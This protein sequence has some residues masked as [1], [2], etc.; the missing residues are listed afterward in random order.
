MSGIVAR[1][2]AQECVLMGRCPAAGYGASNGYDDAAGMS[3]GYG[4]G[5]AGKADKEAHA[6]GPHAGQPPAQQHGPVR[7]GSMTRAVWMARPGPRR[8]VH[9]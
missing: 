3:A 7:P 6:H 5:G 4:H 9:C 2:E 1:G 8:A